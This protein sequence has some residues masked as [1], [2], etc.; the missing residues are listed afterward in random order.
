MSPQYPLS[1]S[2]SLSYFSGNFTRISAAITTPP[3]VES[4]SSGFLSTTVGGIPLIAL[5]GIGVLLAVV[6]AV[7]MYKRKNTIHDWDDNPNMW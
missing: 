2:L 5:I 6:A 1:F 4:G 3:S 7:V